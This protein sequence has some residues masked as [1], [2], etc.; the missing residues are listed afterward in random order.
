[1]NDNMPIQPS[2]KQLDI[3]FYH[4][5]YPLWKYIIE[6]F[7]FDIRD[8]C[9]RVATNEPIIHTNGKKLALRT[10][11]NDY[12]CMLGA[13]YDNDKTFLLNCAN[14]VF[15]ILKEGII[16]R[17]DHIFKPYKFVLDQN[18]NIQI[19]LYEESPND[20]PIAESINNSISLGIVEVLD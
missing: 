13:E 9:A 1:M 2:E 19:Q 20:L 17:G 18:Q 5:A 12:K 16:R 7:E 4:G 10:V 11:S 14:V 6:K 15:D 3:I 8:V